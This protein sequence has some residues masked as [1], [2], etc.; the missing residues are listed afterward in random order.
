MYYPT[1]T[2]KHR[3]CVEGRRKLYAYLAERGVAHRKFGKLIVATDTGEEW[4]QP[5]SLRA[6]IPDRSRARR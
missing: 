1:G 3:L 6:R 5:G 4:L 2:L